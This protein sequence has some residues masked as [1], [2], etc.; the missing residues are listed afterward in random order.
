LPL[1]IVVESDGA[2][3]S[4]ATITFAL[5]VGMWLDKGGIN[6]LCEVLANAQP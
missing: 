3:G 6:V 4:K 5:G 1:D 2:N